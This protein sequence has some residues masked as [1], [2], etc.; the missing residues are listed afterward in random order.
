M[1]NAVG[2]P[3]QNVALQPAAPRPVDATAEAEQR[4]RQREAV[5]EREA[6]HQARESEPPAPR[7]DDPPK[8]APERPKRVDRYA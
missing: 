5:I 2:T 1:V 4:D 7:P 3:A 6:V 8:P